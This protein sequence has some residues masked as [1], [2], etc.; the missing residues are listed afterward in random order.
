MSSL[1]LVLSLL[2]GALLGLLG[3]GGSILTVPLLVYVFGLEPK[4]AIASSLAIVALASVAGAVQ[5]WRKGD[6]KLRTGLPF[7][8]AGMA[9]AYVGGRA[10]AFVDGALLLLL[11]AA[12]MLLTSA[13]MWR[14]RRVPVEVSAGTRPVARLVAQGLAVGL[15]TGLIGAGG[16]FLIVPALALWAGLPMPAAVGTSLLIIVLEQRRRILG[17]RESRRRR[18]PV[19]GGRRDGGDH[20]LLRRRATRAARRSRVA[21]QDLRGVRARDGDL[22]ADPRDPHLA[23]DGARGVPDLCSAVR[24]CAAHARR[25]PRRRA[26]LAPR[27]RRGADRIRIPARRWDT[28]ESGFTPIAGMIG[29]ALIGF[30]SALLLLANGR[31]AGV[32]GILGR[33]FFSAAGDL[34]WRLVFLLGLPLGAWLTGLVFPAT[35]ALAITGSTPLLLLGGFLVGLGTQVGSGCTSGHGVCGIARGSRRSIVATVTF[36]GV[37]IATTFVARHIAGWY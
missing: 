9:G 37:G 4:Q 19:G 34:R 17:L 21:A 2:I 18:L 31:V 8:L 26:R 5:Y 6:V 30:A 23:S 15:F 29:G 1:G 12:M 7:G 36:M 3:G 20:G 13:A 27:R 35:R 28:T 33:S 22:R 11:F 16:G 32:S 25:R 24:I 10:A 14:G